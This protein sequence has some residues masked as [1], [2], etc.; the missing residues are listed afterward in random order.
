M[1][2][3]Q[4]TKY[5]HLDEL[6][7]A[8]PCHSDSHVDELSRP[9]GRDAARCSAA[10]LSTPSALPV[11]RVSVLLQLMPDALTWRFSLVARALHP[12][13]MAYSFRSAVQSVQYVVLY[14]F[15]AVQLAMVYPT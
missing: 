1:E 7:H 14:V 2:R 10:T 3:A 12:S 9:I 8:P 11:Q 13:S 5:D 15:E 6:I 4:T